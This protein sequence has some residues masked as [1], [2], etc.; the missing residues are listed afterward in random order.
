MDI[1]PVIDKSILSNVAELTH[2]GAIRASRRRTN[3]HLLSL[4]PLVALLVV[5]SHRNSE[6]FFTR[7]A[8]D[9]TA[10]PK[11]SQIRGDLFGDA[12]LSQVFTCI[13][14]SAY[15]PSPVTTHSRPNAAS[16]LTP[17]RTFVSEHRVA[18]LSSSNG[19]T[20]FGR[21][22]RV[23]P[24]PLRFHNGSSTRPTICFARAFL[25]H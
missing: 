12:W 7:F 16:S 13:S 6:R 14:P 10:E 18:E 17:L 15:P 20:V 25:C 9:I 5:E 2:G 24:C 21:R 1:I 11:R 23:D 19:N 8:E 3:E 4:N 22:S